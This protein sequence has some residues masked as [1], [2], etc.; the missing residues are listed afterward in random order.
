MGNCCDCKKF[1]REM[2]V[3]I[4]DFAALRDAVSVML[5]YS[6]GAMAR[7]TRSLD[8][9]RESSLRVEDSISRL[10]ALDD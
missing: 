7:W 10:D 2:D 4:E 5:M 8:R 6:D 3:L 1:R 9:V